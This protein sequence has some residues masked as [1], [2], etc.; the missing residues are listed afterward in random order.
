MQEAPRELQALSLPPRVPQGRPPLLILLH[1]MGSDETELFEIAARFD[2]RFHIVSAR[3]PFEYRP[4]YTWLPAT[5]DR[6]GRFRIDEESVGDVRLRLAES[7]S[8][9]ALEHGTDPSRT[10]LLGFS[11]GADVAF[12]T[13]VGVPG[14]AAGVVVLSG[15][16]MAGIEFEDTLGVDG[17]PVFVAHGTHDPLVP[18][19]QGRAIRKFLEIR[20][21]A[22]EYREYP[23]GHE[24]AEETLDDVA[25]WLTERLDEGGWRSWDD[26][27]NAPA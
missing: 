13:G 14:C 16:L 7:I 12:H 10:Y 20:R 4:G 24:V 27:L 19:E 23:V 3:A 8:R 5:V 18:V 1:G 11:Q 15:K 22:G 9:W 2:P 26:A 25:R 6:V 17:L 21:L